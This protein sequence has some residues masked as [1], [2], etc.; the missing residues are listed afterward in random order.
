MASNKKR[1]PDYAS[2]AARKPPEPRPP[3]QPGRW[4]LNNVL[5]WMLCGFILLLVVSDGLLNWS[6]PGIASNELKK[7]R[8]RCVVVSALTLTGFQTTTGI[9]GYTLSRHVFIIFLTMAGSVF[10]MSFAGLAVVR[11]VRLRFTDGQVL[12]GALT[13]CVGFT[14]LGGLVLLFRHPPLEAFML[15]ASAFGNSGLFFGRLPGQ[16]PHGTHGPQ[17]RDQRGTQG[18]EVHHRFREA[19]PKHAVEKRAHQRKQRN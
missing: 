19:T 9:D 15:S 7:D 4:Q 2:P 12:L 14:L 1:I 10:T 5:T 17:E 11:I 6:S 3:A 18:K 13:S 16:L 8:G